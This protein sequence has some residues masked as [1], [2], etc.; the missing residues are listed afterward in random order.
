MSANLLNSALLIGQAFALT[1]LVVA[2]VEGRP[3][4]Q[5]AALFAALLTARAVV[6]WVGDVLVARA[7]TTVGIGVRSQILASALALGPTE[8][9]RR[10]TGE[11]A[12]LATRGAAAVEPYVTRY[13]PALALAAVLPALTVLA[14]ASQ[15]LIA[16]GI[17]IATLPLIPIFAALI[18]IATREQSDR[19]WQTLSS[20]SGHFLDV[21]K[22]LPT[23]V[24]YRRAEAQSTSIREITH[25]YRIATLATLKIAFASSV[26]LELVATLSVALVAVVVGLRLQHGSLDLFT[27]LVVLLLAPEA[28]WPLRRVGAEFHAAAEGVSTFEEVMALAEDASGEADLEA[29]LPVDVDLTIEHLTLRYPGRHDPVFTGLSA[30]IPARG[31]TVISGPSGAGKSTLLAALRGDLAPESGTIRVGGIALDELDPKTWRSQLA[32]VPQRPWILAGSIRE[33]LTLARAEATDEQIW[34]A[35]ERVELAAHVRGLPGGLDAQVAEDGASLSAG[36]RARLALA[37]VVVSDRPVVILDEPTA[38]LDDVTELVI[39]D[40]LEALGRDRCVIVVAHRPELLTRATTHLPLPAEGS[41]N[42]Q[43]LRRVAP[44]LTPRREESR[45]SGEPIVVPATHAKARLALGA[46]LGALASASGV[47]LMATSGWLITRAAEAP[48]VLFLLV[49]IVGVRTFGLA[50]PVF[51]YAERLVSHDVALRLLAER[52]AQVYDALV[53]LVPGRLGKQRGDVLAAVVDDVDALV[54]R[55]LRVRTPLLTWLAVTVIVGLVGLLLEPVSAA[56]LTIGLI[57]GG[58]VGYGIARIGAASAET[59]TIAARAEISSHVTTMLQGAE[60]IRAWQA[61]GPFLARVEATSRVGGRAT[62]RSAIAMA[63]ARLWVLGVCGAITLLVSFRVADLVAADALRGPVAALL[64]LVPI[65]LIDVLLPVA[66]A[67]ALT[68]RTNTADA[69]IRELT[70]ARPAVSSPASPV[71][72]TDKR[73]AIGLVGASAAW[74][75]R[76]VFDPLSVTLTP[77]RRLGVVGPSGSGKSTL[78]SLLLRFIDPASGAV[79]VGSVDARDIALD[80]VRRTVGLVD[81]DPHIFGSTI[82]ENIRLAKPDASRTDVESALGAAQLDDWLAALPKGLDT[83]IGDGADAVSGGERARIALA[84]ALLADPAVLV[85]DEPTAH[86]DA[87]TAQAVTDAVLGSNPDRTLVWVTHGTIGLDEMDEVLTLGT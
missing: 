5:W 18:G 21:M 86:L 33:N 20:L 75:E 87:E 37:R 56:L 34:A 55:Q 26:A 58:L 11:I 39:A 32:V 73:P 67:G 61:E 49:A 47:A 52:R 54:D 63:T 40:T 59:D 31:L 76:Q 4:G 80:D 69:R 7:A 78:V 19:Q 85:L 41:K 72:L 38:H 51:R 68:V 35:L 3:L 64:A 15:D 28:Y 66:E 22:G 12:A 82:F 27:A 71:P 9:S 6:V 83:R 43:I 48:P 81:D 25:R 70:S 45:E 29:T 23:L 16:A 8:R 46:A 50:R 13:L 14:I 53:P 77:G 36:Q 74:G 57:G 17:V 2:V 42:V 62:Q 65:A 1:G 44:S 10:R 30:H 84:R 60:E 24:A 79:V